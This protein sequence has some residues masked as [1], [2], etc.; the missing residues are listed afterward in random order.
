M[1]NWEFLLKLKLGQVHISS[2]YTTC[3]WLLEKTNERRRFKPGTFG[4]TSLKARQKPYLALIG[5]LYSAPSC[6]TAWP[7]LVGYILAVE[8]AAVEAVLSEGE[9]TSICA[10]VTL[11]CRCPNTQ[12]Q[13]RDQAYLWRC[14]CQ[15][16]HCSADMNE[17]Y[18][19][20]FSYFISLHFSWILYDRHRFLCYKA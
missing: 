2:Y 11:I 15:C 12:I 6:R 8:E 1:Q 20:T 17:G 14:P 3:K 10:P 19:I 18:N 7:W 9:A 4:A 13:R 16:W 5:R